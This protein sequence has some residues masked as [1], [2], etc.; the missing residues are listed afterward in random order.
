MYRVAICDDESKIL[1]DIYAKVE[2]CFREQKMDA[3]YVCIEDSR[4]MMECL[5][6]E[7]FDVVFLD[8]DMPYISGMDIAAFL[9][10][11]KK[12][13]LLVFVTS[14]DMLVYQTFAYRPFGFI[15][16]TRID[17][18]L[19][20]LVERLQ[21]EFVDRKQDLI[22]KKRQERIRVYIHDIMYVES[23]GNYLNFVTF[24]DTIKIR[25]TM[26]NIEKELG[27]NGFVRCHKGYLVNGEYIERIRNAEIELQCNG[28]RKN[29]PVGRS[30]EKDVRKNIME[31]IRN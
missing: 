7:E 20:E 21:K 19:K 13:T 27:C 23:E 31:L 12:N 1:N 14:Q 6:N 2:E 3:K 8:I 22:L 18:E 16:K 30:Y 25:D 29:L 9:N 4:K 15:R 24:H 10:E 17:A 5:Q 28:V 11:K 26:T